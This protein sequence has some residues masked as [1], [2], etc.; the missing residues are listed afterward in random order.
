[1]GTINPL[2]PNFDS[3]G[4][5]IWLEFQMGN[6]PPLAPRLPIS[7]VPFSLSTIR[8]DGDLQTGS[9]FVRIRDTDNSPDDGAIV[10]TRGPETHV[11]ITNEGRDR[12]QLSSSPQGSSHVF[13]W[14]SQADLGAS[15][16]TGTSGSQLRLID[17]F[18][19]VFTELSVSANDSASEQTMSVRQ[20]ESVSK[21]IDKST[22]LLA[23]SLWSHSPAVGDCTQVDL[24]SRS[25]GSSLHL[26]SFFDIFTE[27]SFS[28]SNS[29]SDMSMQATD[30]VGSVGKRIDKATPLLA[31]S[32]W[33]HSPAVGDCTMV[34][35]ESNGSGSSLHL[36][37][38]FDVFTELSLSSTDFGSDMTMR[39]TDAAG[40][41]SK[42]IDKA[43]PLLA[44]ALCVNNSTPGSTD[45]TAVEMRADGG[46]S[47]TWAV[48]SFFDIFTEVSLSTGNGSGSSLLHSSQGNAS[49][50][51]VTEVSPLSSSCFLGHS[52]GSNVGLAGLRVENTGSSSQLMDSF[53]DITYRIDC[54][55]A[56]TG[57]SMQLAALDNTGTYSAI[58][59]ADVDGDATVS[60][61]DLACPGSGGGGAGG[62]IRLLTDASSSS[63]A[64]GQNGSPSSFAIGDLNG[65]GRLDLVTGGPGGGGGRISISNFSPSGGD[66]VSMSSGG[67]GGG[68]RIS[69]RR[70]APGMIPIEMIAMELTSVGPSITLRSASSDP[71]SPPACEYSYDGLSRLIRVMRSE[72]GQLGD[73]TVE[74]STGMTVYS[75]QFTNMFD[76]RGLTFLG[77]TGVAAA[78]TPSGNL[79]VQGGGRVAIEPP[80]F[81]GVGTMNPSQKLSVEGNICATGLIGPCSDARYKK[82]IRTLD[83]AIAKVLSLRGVGFDWKTEE[84]AEKHFSEAHQVG[85]IAQ[86]V[87]EVLP[88]VVS[89]GTD[90]YY[91]V[92]Y[93]RITPLLVE[94]I[95]EQQKVIESQ[96]EEIDLL[97][98]KYSALDEKLDALLEQQTATKVKFSSVDE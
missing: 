39:A 10:D 64:M 95:K 55:A 65:D 31:K 83:G 32:L 84:Y 67:G 60:L 86:E 93:G 59:R 36:D 75:D 54:A 52:Q 30:A 78:I 69:I 23:K 1:L 94:A 9:G 29:G 5:Q 4:G 20:G 68:G 25:T 58:M 79:T 19:D 18:F 87:L 45:S 15:M 90:G 61:L 76:D 97:N 81:F 7:S 33:S 70:E 26:D 37:S 27:L 38:F 16:E 34:D 74:S 53:F 89:K 24:S 2:P 40:S 13:L 71:A 17:S 51:C 44:K 91:S 96:K 6:D 28:S 98:R 3:P 62:S 56:D 41:T 42:R 49:S 21:R 88:E 66:A 8:V 14:N 22:P 12:L 63:I 57:A 80:A 48:D 35:L 85:M 73:S 43:T 92:D 72:P 77:P 82:N 46:G 47:G 50:E 11:T